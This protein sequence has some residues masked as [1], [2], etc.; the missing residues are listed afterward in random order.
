LKRGRS[1]ATN[2]PLLGLSLGGAQVGD[3]LKFDAAQKRVKFTVGLRSIVAVDHLD[4][5]CNGRVVRSFVKHSPIDHADLEGSIPLSGSG[6]CVLRA[7]SDAARYPVLDNYVYATTSPIYITIAG[8]KPRSSEDAKYFAAW[9]DRMT[10]TTA[11]Y[12]DWNNDAEKRSVL[13]RL[14]QAKAVFVGLE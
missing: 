5:V 10:E 13:S 7:F 6:W 11:A 2:G 4:L 3:E 1:F 12:P 14:A 9:I 8:A